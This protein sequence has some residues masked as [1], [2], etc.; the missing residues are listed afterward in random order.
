MVKRCP[1]GSRRN[2]RTGECDTHNKA[3]TAKMPRCARGSRRNK[4]TKLCVRN[5]VKP[6]TAAAFEEL[7]GIAETARHAT[8]KQILV[9]TELA[10]IAQDAK[11]MSSNVTRRSKR[12][13]PIIEEYDDPDDQRDKTLVGIYSDD[14][15]SLVP[16]KK[17][18]KR[19]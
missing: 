1:R 10:R 6:R 11:R 3:T 9:Q 19:R 7:K 12:L 4:T 18:K 13:S 15:E 14:I 16:K 5:S 2:K 17:K 8:Q